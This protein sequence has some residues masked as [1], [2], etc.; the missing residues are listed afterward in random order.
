M[1][2]IRTTRPVSCVNGFYFLLIQE[3][4]WEIGMT[5]IIVS[6]IPFVPIFKSGFKHLKDPVNSPTPDVSSQLSSLLA[7]QTF[8][9]HPKIIEEGNDLPHFTHCAFNHPAFSSKYRHC[10]RMYRN[11]VVDSNLCFF[12]PQTLPD[13]ENKAFDFTMKPT[14]RI[15]MINKK[16]STARMLNCNTSASKIV[17]KLTPA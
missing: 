14:D 12:V 11:G 9:F 7:K 4:E 8:L 6:V 15:A 16:P 13:A 3:K 2:I 10:S 17:I 5:F 1:I